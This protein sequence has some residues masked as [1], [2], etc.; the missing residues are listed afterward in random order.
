MRFRLISI[1][2]DEKHAS[3]AKLSHLDLSKRRFELEE[4]FD[5]TIT[6]IPDLCMPAIYRLAGE[7]D[8]FNKTKSLKLLPFRKQIDFEVC[9]SPELI[10]RNIIRPIAKVNTKTVKVS[11]TLECEHQ[12]KGALNLNKTNDRKIKVSFKKVATR[13]D[14][15][16]AKQLQREKYKEE[17][18]D[19]SSN[20]HKS[21]YISNDSRKKLRSRNELNRRYSKLRVKKKDESNKEETNNYEIGFD[22]LFRNK[23]HCNY[24]FANPMTD[25]MLTDDNI[26]NLRK[27]IVSSRDIEWKMLTP[28]RPDNEYEERYFDKLINLHRNRYKSRVESGYF[29]SENRRVP[30]KHTRHT[31]LFQS[32][33][34]S[35]K[36]R[37]QSLI[38]DSKTGNSK[39]KIQIPTLTLTEAEVK[40]DELTVSN[41][42]PESASHAS[43]AASVEETDVASGGADEDDVN[44]EDSELDDIYQEY[45]YEYFSRFSRRNI[46]KSR[47]MERKKNN[48]SNAQFD[49]M[50]AFEANDEPSSSQQNLDFLQ[51]DVLEDQV[52]EIITHLMSS[53]LSGAGVELKK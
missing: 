51:D 15:S 43:K 44:D 7:D 53:S 49:N 2:M 14:N 47:N 19:Y 39:Q 22:R 33:L 11:K 13:E 4:I 6:K 46:Q 48:Q 10:D 36:C 5:S 21:Y 34:Q 20:N 31:F 26:D 37:S 40:P 16:V 25:C 38:D 23:P 29:K 30:F 24:P 8:Y 9:S 32:G 28:I 45:N 1:K 50:S 27:I 3:I 17:H 42:L 18:A 35:Q 12:D 41:E 52:E